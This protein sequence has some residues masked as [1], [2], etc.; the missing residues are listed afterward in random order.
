M[1]AREFLVYEPLEAFPGFTVTAGNMWVFP[2]SCRVGNFSLPGTDEGERWGRGRY[3]CS[4]LLKH[5]RSTGALRSADARAALFT[6][7]HMEQ[8]ARHGFIGASNPILGRFSAILRLLVCEMILEVAA[9]L[10]AVA[11]SSLAGLERSSTTCLVSLTHI[12]SHCVLNCGLLTGQNICF[13]CLVS[14]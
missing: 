8:R 14:V 5:I 1:I 6:H 4:S 7:S 10:I 2:N 13:L 11:V 12:S 9:A 3:D